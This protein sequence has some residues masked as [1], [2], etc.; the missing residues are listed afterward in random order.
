MNENAQKNRHDDI[1]P[2]DY[3]RVKL[4]KDD[5]HRSD[6]INASFIRVKLKLLFMEDF[7]EFAESFL[8]PG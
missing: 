4:V 8:N 7:S 6:Y 3:N 5:V 2:Y 1:L